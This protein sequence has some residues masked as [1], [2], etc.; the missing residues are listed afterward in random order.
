M[1]EIDYILSRL[2]KWI[3]HYN[4][5]YRNWSNYSQALLGSM[6]RKGSQWILDMDD[7]LYY[8]PKMYQVGD[9]TPLIRELGTTKRGRVALAHPDYKESLLEDFLD[10]VLS[11]DDMAVEK[12]HDA[13]KDP[14]RFF[15]DYI[16]SE[17]RYEEEFEMRY[18]F[19]P[20]E[21]NEQPIE[22]YFEGTGDLWWAVNNGKK[23]KDIFLK[24][25]END[26]S[27][28]IEHFYNLSLSDYV[29]V[30]VEG[31]LLAELQKAEKEFP[32][33]MGGEAFPQMKKLQTLF[34]SSDIESIRQ[35][36]E[37]VNAL[38]DDYDL[39][40]MLQVIKDKIEEAA[41][42][43]QQ[44]IIDA[45]QNISS[46]IEAEVE[47]MYDNIWYDFSESSDGKLNRTKEG[48]E[49]GKFE[50]YELM[51]LMSEE[52]IESHIE[53]EHNLTLNNNLDLYV[54]EY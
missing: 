32:K 36:I 4:N 44:E 49:N 17:E 45:Y 27:K 46:L 11:E 41:E 6:D 19:L 5:D 42:P 2:A 47:N 7:L 22:E 50:H 37:L 40:P 21:W 48:I 35:A 43:I 54:G 9:L 23:L 12:F 33:S 51:D 28:S 24:E 18:G 8:G 15:D 31:Y 38:A 1:K 10:K 16:A 53:I 34:E 25:I 14:R 13:L 39:S 26:S 20:D 29:G 3:A 30:E 52:A